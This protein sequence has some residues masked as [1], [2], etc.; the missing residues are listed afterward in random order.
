M[1]VEPGNHAEELYTLARSAR[2]NSCPST[3]WR[4]FDL[5]QIHVVHAGLRCAK[6]ELLLT[7]NGVVDS[8]LIGIAAPHAGAACFHCGLLV[9]GTSYQVKVEGI[10]RDTCC[11][12]CQEVPQ[13]IA[14]NLLETK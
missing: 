10:I 3:A 12:G 4:M 9:T 5:D 2:R 6:R 7:M 8:P 1:G 13:T 14:E 11:R